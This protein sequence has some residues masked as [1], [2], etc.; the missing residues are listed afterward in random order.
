MLLQPSGTVPGRLFDTQVAAAFLGFAPQVGYAELVARQ[1]GPFHR[2]GPDA[3]RLVA[4]AAH[5]GA[6]RLCRRRR[7]APP[8]V[9]RGS[10]AAGRERPG[11]LGGRRS[12]GR[13]ESSAVSHRPGDGLASDEGIGPVA[14]GRTVGGSGA[15]RMARTA[16]DRIRQATR[17]DPVRRSALCARDPRTRVDRGAGI[18]RRAAA[19]R[20]P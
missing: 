6:A 4:P 7:A 14:A 2:Q 3:H 19:E 5:G 17:L 13:R 10:A 8:Y 9:A 15:G 18:H 16:R 12:V 11:I 1:L 20:R